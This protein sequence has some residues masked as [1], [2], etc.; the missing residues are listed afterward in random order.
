MEFQVMSYIKRNINFS[1]KPIKRDAI[2]G[3]GID[4]HKHNLTAA[5]A[6]K[7]L[8]TIRIVKVQPFTTDDGGVCPIVSK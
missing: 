7:K 2:Y 1:Q 6:E 3:V 5:I 4:V 8:D